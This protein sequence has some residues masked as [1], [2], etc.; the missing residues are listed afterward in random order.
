MVSGTR[1]IPLYWTSAGTTRKL[2]IVTHRLHAHL[3]LQLPV[4][5]VKSRP[6]P[7]RGGS[8]ITKTRVNSWIDSSWAVESISRGDT[9]RVILVLLDVRHLGV[10]LFIAGCEAELQMREDETQIN[11][12]IRTLSRGVYL[13]FLGR[14][15]LFPNFLPGYR[16]SA[17]HPV[18]DKKPQFWVCMP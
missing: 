14:A 8:A 4:D 10:C 9:L 11:S 2:V 5:L 3:P 6:S 17:G 16:L 7:I 18:Q 12:T 1:S 13:D 15:R